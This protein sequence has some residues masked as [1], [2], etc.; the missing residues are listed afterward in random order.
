[1]Q[2]GQA[3]GEG[4]R[5][6]HNVVIPIG[7]TGGYFPV[8]LDYYT[9]WGLDDNIFFDVR[10]PSGSGVGPPVDRVMLRALGAK[11]ARA[12]RGYLALLFEWDR[13]GGRKGKLVRP[14]RPRVRRNN[15]GE[16]LDGE[17]EIIRNK[18][19]NPKVSPYTEGAISLGGREPNPAVDRYPLYQPEDLLELCYPPTMRKY[20]A[21][22][23]IKK[24][25]A[26]RR[27]R[28][29]LEFLEKSGACVIERLGARRPIFRKGNVIGT[30]A[31]YPWRIVPPNQ[32][33]SG[34]VDLGFGGAGKGQ[35]SIDL[36]GS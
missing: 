23:S 15:K 27:A 35:L 8:R 36:D 32:F 20:L 17:G 19:G 3:L 10:L 7:L 2:S 22:T 24:A 6:L 1:M 30:S 16:V 31:G 21:S 13:Y 28:A 9:G 11:S 12:Y 14:T 4:I 5:N 29:S 25:N 26:V 18:T 34:P 33:S